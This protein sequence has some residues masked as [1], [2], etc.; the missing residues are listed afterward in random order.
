MADLVT[1][2]ADVK[3]SDKVKSVTEPH[4]YSVV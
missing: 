1:Y 3:V 4:I 2:L